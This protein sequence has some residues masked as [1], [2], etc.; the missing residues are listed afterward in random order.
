LLFLLR[1][2]RGTYSVKTR[3]HMQ[4][5]WCRH[6]TY[7]SNDSLSFVFIASQKIQSDLHN[8]INWRSL[9]YRIVYFPEISAVFRRNVHFSASWNNIFTM[10]LDK[11][12]LRGR[13]NGAS[14]PSIVVYFTICLLSKHRSRE[15]FNGF[16]REKYGGETRTRLH[17]TSDL[18][19]GIKK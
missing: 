3:G 14:N 7:N 10:I 13:I 16:N 19:R 4:R 2:M 12:F 18:R 6:C 5:K 8:E 15:T 9:R 11:R 1:Q 17:R